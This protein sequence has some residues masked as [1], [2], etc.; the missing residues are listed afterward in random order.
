VVASAR[1]DVY[2][3]TVVSQPSQQIKKALM[4]TQLKVFKHQYQPDWFVADETGVILIDGCV[5]MDA[6][7]IARQKLLARATKHPRDTRYN[8]G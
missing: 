5:S 6:A 8:P 4:E 2:R 7:I 1:A 3:T